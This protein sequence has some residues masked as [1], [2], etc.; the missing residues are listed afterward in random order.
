ML[1]LRQH[2]RTH[3]KRHSAVQAPFAAVLRFEVQRQWVGVHPCFDGLYWLCFFYHCL[4]QKT[5]SRKGNGLLFRTSV[6]PRI[7][8]F[9]LVASVIDAAFPT[10]GKRRKAFRKVPFRYLE[11]Y[12]FAPAYRCVCYRFF[13]YARLLGQGRL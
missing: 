9:A 2:S 5:M 8:P 1:N 12:H 6:F 10:A 11:K 4:Y 3:T 7:S 13:R